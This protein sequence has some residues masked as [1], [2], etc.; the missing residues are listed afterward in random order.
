[1]ILE[2]IFY[3]LILNYLLFT[4]LPPNGGYISRCYYDHISFH[5]SNNDLTSDQTGI[6]QKH[7]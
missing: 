5:I 2:C 4:K 7:L 1:M 3:I 6:D